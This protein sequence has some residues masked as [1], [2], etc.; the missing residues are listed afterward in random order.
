MVLKLLK[1]ELI[2]N[3]KRYLGLYIA[4]FATAVVAALS[5]TMIHSDT[6]DIFYLIFG[7]FSFGFFGLII[8]CFIVCIIQGVM[9]FHQS[10][11]KSESYITHAVPS[12]TN[13]ILISKLIG[14]TFWTFVS[15]IVSFIA[16]IIY[17][18]VTASIVDLSGLQSFLQLVFQNI[19]FDDV[20]ELIVELLKW[21]PV[22]L[23]SGILLFATLFFCDSITQTQHTPTHRVLL[24]VLVYIGITFITSII[25]TALSGVLDPEAYYYYT[26]TPWSTVIIQTLFNLIQIVI[27]Y[28]GCKWVIDKKMEV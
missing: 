20:I 9:G 10:M 17:A 4:T 25:T 28:V 13:E 16:I 6:N 8:A 3:Y 5:T 15:F 11:F 14:A 22:A 21:S 7:L 12:T 26:S 18:L 24:S 27:F 1:Y 19:Y 2:N 23:S